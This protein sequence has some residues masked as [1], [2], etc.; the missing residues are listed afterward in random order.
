V[1][2]S[3]HDGSGVRDRLTRALHHGVAAA[4]CFLALLG[5][6]AAAAVN[7]VARRVVWLASLLFAAI[8]AVVFVLWG[9]AQLLNDWLGHPGLEQIIVGLAVL[10]LVAVVLSLSGMDEAPRKQDGSGDDQ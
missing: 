1:P 5:A 3:D 8:L 4:R 9:A 7:R 10:A 2:E 6:E